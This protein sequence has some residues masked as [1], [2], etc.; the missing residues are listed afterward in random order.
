MS[1]RT[2][3]VP[4]LTLEQLRERWGVSED[5]IRDHIKNDSLPFVPIGGG[6]KRPIYRFRIAAVEAWEAA[7]ERAIA[8]EKAD[9]PALPP[10]SVASMWDGKIRGTSGKRRKT[11]K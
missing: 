10:P 5:V 3:P 11:A 8:P 1:T 7:R 4:L 2:T 6:K 9:L